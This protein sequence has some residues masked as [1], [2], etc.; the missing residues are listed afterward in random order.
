MQHHD[1]SVGTWAKQYHL[2][3]RGLIESILREHDLG[4]TQWYVLYQ[5]VKVGPTRQ[6]DLGRLLK[7][8]RATL[9]GIVATLVRKGLIDQVPDTVDQRQRTLLITAAGRKLWDDLPDPIAL[10]NTIAFKGVDAAD[11]AT[12]MRVLQA[13]TNRLNGHMAAAGE[14]QG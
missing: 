12:A 14:P 2:A 10:T 4:P 9:S 7:L 3:A 5:L 1:E 11:L 6:R 8:E 13:A